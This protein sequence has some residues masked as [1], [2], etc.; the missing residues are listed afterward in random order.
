VGWR[1]NKNLGLVV[2]LP[3]SIEEA[4]TNDW[5]RAGSLNSESMDFSFALIDLASFVIED[6]RPRLFE[7][8]GHCSAY[9]D[10]HTY[11]HL[12]VQLV[13]PVGHVTHATGQDA[14][15]GLVARDADAADRAVG[16]DVGHLAA[17]AVD[18]RGHAGARCSNQGLRAEVLLC[19]AAPLPTDARDAIR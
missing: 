17:V 18:E 14:A 4:T 2:R 16:A 15:H 3:P 8:V 10:L 12:P 13:H 9:V 1:F 5:P 11:E 6:A 19:V 7:L